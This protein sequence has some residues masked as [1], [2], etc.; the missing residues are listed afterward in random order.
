MN[1]S[2]RAGQ[3]PRSGRVALVAAFL[4]AI[5]LT[6]APRLARATPIDDAAEAYKAA[7]QT[8]IDSIVAGLRKLVE[9]LKKGDIPAARQAWIDARVGYERSE[10]FAEPLFPD[11]D[12]AIDTWPEAKTGFHA[13]EAKLFVDGATPPLTEAADLLMTAKALQAAMPK[14]KLTGETLIGGIASLAFEVGE[15]KSK[16][17]E[18]RVSGTSLNDMQHNV[19]GIERAWNSVFAA[20]VAAKD[21]RLAKRI[22]DQLAEVKSLVSVSSLDKLDPP[23]F[24]K[25][26]EML[27]GSIADAAVAL[28]YPAP[29][30]EEEEGE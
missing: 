6:A 7:A 10:T 12:T 25:K 11:L 5:S 16:G 28:G 23:S 9:A 30:F 20:P 8:D 22:Q 3:A 18:S 15:G 26:A 4:A 14:A 13:V 17:G 19:E 27:V 1:L 2:L 24:E 21:P 29:K